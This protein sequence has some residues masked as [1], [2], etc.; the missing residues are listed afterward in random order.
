METTQNN[1]QQK[2]KVVKVKAHIKANATIRFY[3]DGGRNLPKKKRN[4]YF[5]KVDGVPVKVSEDVYYAY[6]Y[7]KR[8]EKTWEEKDGRNGVVSYDALDT[9]QTNGEEAFPDPNS[10]EDLVITNVLIEQLHIHMAKLPLADQELLYQLYFEGLSERKIAEK[11][12]VPKSTVS[13][14]RLRAIAKLKKFFENS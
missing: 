12:G 9:E 7:Y 13:D 4:A 3:E 14:R 2:F 5:I 10:I 1:K 11:T 6:H 8:K